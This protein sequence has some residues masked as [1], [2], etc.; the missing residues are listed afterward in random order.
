VTSGGAGYAVAAS[1]AFAYLPTGLTYPGTAL[2]VRVF[3]RIVPAEVVQAPL[4]DPPGARLR[5]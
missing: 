1:I 4:W 5:G 2:S 3:D